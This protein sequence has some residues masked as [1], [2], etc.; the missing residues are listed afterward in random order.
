MA[1]F[2]KLEENSSQEMEP[3][4]TSVPD[5]NEKLDTPKKD[6]KLKVNTKR[7]EA[8]KSQ[9]ETL[10]TMSE[11]RNNPR[12]H[13]V[14]MTIAHEMASSDASYEIQRLKEMK[15]L[16]KW[17]YITNR[18][19]TNDPN[20]FVNEIKKKEKQASEAGYAWRLKEFMQAVSDKNFATAAICYIELKNIKEFEEDTLKYE[21]IKK[22]LEIIVQKIQVPEQIKL[23]D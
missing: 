3:V 8:S 6:K 11:Q 23:N 16:P 20:Y 22:S 13:Y 4:H 21:T 12:D 17:D 5:K 10:I 9:M 18:K 15:V 2:M 14:I 7:K 19:I 1:E